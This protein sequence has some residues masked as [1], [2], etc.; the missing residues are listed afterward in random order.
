LG[1]CYFRNQ[2]NLGALAFFVAIGL[3]H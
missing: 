2:A 3:R 1:P